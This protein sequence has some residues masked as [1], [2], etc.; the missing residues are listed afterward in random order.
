M[1]EGAYYFTQLERACRKKMNKGK[2]IYV[3]D[4]E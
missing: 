1:N 2:F 4:Y 3:T